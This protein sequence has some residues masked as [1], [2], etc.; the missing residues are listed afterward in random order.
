MHSAG[1][2]HR[3]KWAAG[4]GIVLICC[5]VVAICAFGLFSRFMA[6]MNDREIERQRELAETRFQEVL[7]RLRA[8]CPYFGLSM[9][10]CPGADE[11]LRR[12]CEVR[13]LTHINLELTDVSDMGLGCVANLPNLQ[14]LVLSQGHVTDQGIKN[15]VN[16]RSLQTLVLDRTMVTA[17]GLLALRTLSHLRYLLY[18]VDIPDPT[19]RCAVET[20]VAALKELRG[21]QKLEIGGNWVSDEIVRDLQGTHCTGSVTWLR[22]RDDRWFCQGGFIPPDSLGRKGHQ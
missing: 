9:D 20:I 19:D 1:S 8:G 12:A 22:D 17:D 3:Y 6:P 16:M 15:L 4:C 2:T 21:L 14:V 5:V 13:G 11:K 10:D 18:D 7:D